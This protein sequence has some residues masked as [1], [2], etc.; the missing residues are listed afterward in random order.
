MTE[1]FSVGLDIL[2]G[3]RS[4]LESMLPSLVDLLHMGHTTSSSGPPPVC[5]VRPSVFAELSSWVAARCASLLLDMVRNLGG[6]K[7]F[8]KYSGK[9]L[10]FHG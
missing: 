6:K 8:I 10:E 7:H 4:L 5:L 3:G 1:L 9:F 2:V